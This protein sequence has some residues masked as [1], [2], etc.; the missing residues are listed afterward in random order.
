MEVAIK[1][2]ERNLNTFIHFIPEIYIKDYIESEIYVLYGFLSEE[3]A[4]GVAL[5]EIGVRDVII[6]YLYLLE[7]HTHLLSYFLHFIEYD[8]YQIGRERFLWKF[9]DDETGTYRQMLRALGF[10]ISQGENAV[11]RFRLE[12]LEKVTLLKKQPK[13]VVSLEQVDNLRLKKLSAEIEEQGSAILSF[14]IQKEEYIADCSAVII[15]QNE[16]KAMLL[17]QRDENGELYIPYIY[18]KAKDPMAIVEM[19][20]FM[21]RKAKEQFDENETCVTYVVQ[22]ILVKIIEKLIGTKGQYQYIA[23]RNFELTELAVSQVEKIFA[24]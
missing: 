9:L 24:E 17:L 18:S 10:Y 11:F 16:P 21:V 23:M 6:E 3:Q 13:N 14:P 22:P 4:C 19:I 2:E 7:S 5:L 8:M 15:E 20:R 12:E 1:V